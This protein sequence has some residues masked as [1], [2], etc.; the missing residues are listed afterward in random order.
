M[1]TC[2]TVKNAFPFSTQFYFGFKHFFL[3]VSN[4]LTYDFFY[5]DKFFRILLHTNLRR[6]ITK[7]YDVFIP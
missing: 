2:Y 7:E 5:G 6:L 1:N 4:I 3:F